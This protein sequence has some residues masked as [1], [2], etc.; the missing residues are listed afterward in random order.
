MEARFIAA[1]T[2]RDRKVFQLFHEAWKASVREVNEKGSAEGPLSLQQIKVRFGEFNLPASPRPVPRHAVDQGDKFRPVDNGS[3]YQGLHNMAYSP[4]EVV[5]LM[6]A[7][8]TAGVARSFFDSYTARGEPCPE[9]AVSRDDE[10]SAY[11]NVPT[12]EP[13]FHIAIAISPKSGQAKYFIVRGHAFGFSASVTN[14]SA[15]PRK[16]LF[17]R[18]YHPSCSPRPSPPTSTISLPRNYIP[19]RSRVPRCRRLAPFSWLSAGCAVNRRGT[20]WFSIV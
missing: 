5:G 20:F 13:E 19:A 18:S 12:A 14:Y 4:R 1:K 2:G 15:T 3:H 10:P 6:P 7:D 8:Y 16:A 9:I 17:S 11:R